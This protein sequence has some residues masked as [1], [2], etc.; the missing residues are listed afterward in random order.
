MKQTITL[1]VE[2]DVSGNRISDP[3]TGPDEVV[4]IRVDEL[5]LSQGDSFTC[6]QAEAHFGDL[7]DFAL[8]EI[9]SMAW[10]DE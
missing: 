7:I 5:R 2:V 9:D 1:T 8:D 4:D 6:K 10:E 3:E